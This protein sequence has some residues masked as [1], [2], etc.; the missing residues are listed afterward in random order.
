MKAK[1]TPLVV[2]EDDRG[3]E[4]LRLIRMQ[5]AATRCA[6]RLPQ[7]AAGGGSSGDTT[8]LT[9]HHS[10]ALGQL[11]TGTDPDGHTIKWFDA[12]GLPRDRKTCADLVRGGRQ[13]KRAAQRLAKR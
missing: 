5:A 11:D 8:T 9:L 7:G 12:G 13:G 10:N 4:L 3:V 1:S 6:T 2:D